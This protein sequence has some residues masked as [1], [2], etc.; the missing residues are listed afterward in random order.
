MY[1][2]AMKIR[3]DFA[4]LDHEKNPTIRR[5]PQ[6]FKIFVFHF[7]IMHIDYTQTEREKAEPHIISLQMPPELSSYSSYLLIYSILLFSA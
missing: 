1:N 3:H 4:V 7:M 6:L 2:R 5:L